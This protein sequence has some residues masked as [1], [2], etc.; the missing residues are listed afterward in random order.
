VA[1]GEDNLCDRRTLPGHLTGAALVVYE[2]DQTALLI[3]HKFLQR[4]L[5]PGGH[6]DPSEHPQ[7]GALRELTEEVGAGLDVTLHPWHVK[8]GIPL[9]IDSHAI[10]ANQAKNEPAHVHHDWLYLFSAVNKENLVLQQTEVSSFTWVPLADVRDGNF[11]ARLGRA[12]QKI[13]RLQLVTPSCG[14]C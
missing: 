13:Q 9:D 3:R 6:L 7:A 8:N 1:L 10:P 11:G 12:C 2:P 5:Q 4:W 14:A